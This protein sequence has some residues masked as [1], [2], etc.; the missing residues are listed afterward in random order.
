MRVSD[1]NQS[2]Y[3]IFISQKFIHIYRVKNLIYSRPF[4]I[5][6]QQFSTFP[7]VKKWE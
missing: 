1:F 2:D 5:I 4:E 6:V 7:P 3:S